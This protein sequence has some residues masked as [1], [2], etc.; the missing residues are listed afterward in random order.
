MEADRLE[1]RLDPERRRK[2]S[3]IAESRGLTVSYTVRELIDE[4]YEGQRTYRQRLADEIAYRME[5][6]RC[7]Q[8]LT[9]Q[10]NSAYDV[11]SP[12]SPT[13][14]YLDRLTMTASSRAAASF[15]WQQTIRGLSGRTPKSSRSCSIAI[16]RSIAGSR[17]E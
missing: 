9:R 16:A 4:A 5:I 14:S 6:G 17:G 2:L 15:G 3:R 1:V 8:D 13:S 7:R 10:L 11:T 12:S